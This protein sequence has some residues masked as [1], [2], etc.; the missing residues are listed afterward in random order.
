MGYRDISQRHDAAAAELANTSYETRE[1]AWELAQPRIDSSRVRFLMEMGADVAGAM[2]L[3]NISED[4]VMRHP[5][6]R[7]LQLQRH[8]HAEQ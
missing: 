7:A 8:L 5:Q 4:H 2:T 1:L 6:L 3:A